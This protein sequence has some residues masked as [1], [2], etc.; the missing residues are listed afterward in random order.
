[1]GG[2]GGG[3]AEDNLLLLLIINGVVFSWPTVGDASRLTECYT[4]PAPSL[5]LMVCV[6]FIGL[7][8]DVVVVSVIGRRE[9][10]GAHSGDIFN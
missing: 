1:M 5:A 2:R 3:V 7:S 4:Y 9:R 10:E 6:V 8:F